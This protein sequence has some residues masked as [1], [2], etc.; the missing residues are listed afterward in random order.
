MFERMCG[1][2]A[3]VVG[4]HTAIE[5]LSR[6]YIEAVVGAAKDIRVVHGLYHSTRFLSFIW[7]LGG[8]PETSRRA[9]SESLARNLLL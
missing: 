8:L 3:I 9:M 4:L 6:T 7:L 2:P 1:T 5:I